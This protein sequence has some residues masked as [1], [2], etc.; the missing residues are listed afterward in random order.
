M[1]EPNVVPTSEAARRLGVTQGRV[2]Q[3]MDSGELGFVPF[4]GVRRLVTVS[5]LQ[6]LIDARETKRNAPAK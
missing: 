1:A 5:S 6:R 2:R 3:L 4:G